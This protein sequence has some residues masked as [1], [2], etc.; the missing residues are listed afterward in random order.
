MWY[1]FRTTIY[2]NIR[3]LFIYILVLWEIYPLF[4]L[5]S[6]RLFR[7]CIISL[8]YFHDVQC[9]IIVHVCIVKNHFQFVFLGKVFVEFFLV[10]LLL[11]SHFQ[12]FVAILNNE[13][14][15]WNTHCIWRQ[16][17]VFGKLHCMLIYFLKRYIMT[18]HDHVKKLSLLREFI[19][20]SIFP[21]QSNVWCLLS[22]FKRVMCSSKQFTFEQFN[23]YAAFFLNC[24]I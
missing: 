11:I 21:Y 18:F 7:M 10:L 5:H 6:F 19:R 1:A 4:F 16:T 8:D 15:A 13:N 3:N 20:I 24:H 22:F 12:F 9:A 23:L 17:N 14:R 2:V